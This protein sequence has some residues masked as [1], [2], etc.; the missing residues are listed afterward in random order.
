MSIRVEE[1]ISSELRPLLQ[2]VFFEENSASIP[3][4]YAA[5]KPE[6]AR[7]W[8]L[9]ALRNV[10]TL[11]TYYHVLDILGKRMQEHPSARLTLTGCNAGEQ[12]GTQLSRQRAENVKAYLTSI[13][14]VKPARITV[15][16]RGL[17]EKA[18]DPNNPDGVAE[19]RR[20]EFTSDT[21]DVIAP[22]TIDDTLRT[23]T[24][25]TLRLRPSVTS[26]AGLTEWSVAVTQGG[27]TLRR[28]AGTGAVPEL[29]DWRI[30]QDRALI[31]RSDE[32]VHYSL[33]VRDAANQ[34]RATPPAS[35]PV[36]QITIQ[37]KRSERIADKQIDRYN[38]ILFDFDSPAI[39]AQNARIAEYIR[40]RITPQATVSVTGYTD[41]MG[42]EEHNRKLSQ[43]RAASTAAALGR[44]DAVVKGMGE[45]EMYDNNLP[46]GRFYCRTVGVVVEQPVK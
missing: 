8:S 22:V 23:V 33:A 13:W 42:N 35:I 37:K 34:E 2:Y 46:E 45:S 5:L 4:R 44:S 16:D 19:N 43:D 39:N 26:D 20:V 6:E 21:W 14:G 40:Q 7:A 10:G 18:S 27:A 12:G 32:P 3:P 25:P 30:D 1:Y 29:L 9:A 28:F 41:R 31:P 36:E 38:L 15:R 17:P 11:E 24:P